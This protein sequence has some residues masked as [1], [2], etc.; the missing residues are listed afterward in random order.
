ML[1]KAR[2]DLRIASN[3]PKNVSLA[4][5]LRLELRVAFLRSMELYP[6]RKSNPE[7]LKM[8]WIQ[9]SGLMEHI[10]KQHG[11]ARDVPEAFSTKL[12]RR[13]ASTMPPRP[14]IQPSFDD[15]YTQ[16]KQMFQD[17]RDVMDVLKYV[18]PQCLLVGCSIFPLHYCPRVL[19]NLRC[20][21][22]WRPFKRGN[23][24]PSSSSAP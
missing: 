13:L 11:L 16:F 12:Q 14:I 5:D 6:L 21:T 24:S 3:I 20:R 10:K 9:M 7:S 19:A 1:Q 15:T 8:P 4:L 22:P 23:H 18:D 2:A 17:G